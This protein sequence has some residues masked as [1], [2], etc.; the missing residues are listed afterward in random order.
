MVF[1]K[2]AKAAIM[3][4]ILSEVL[5]LEDDSAVHK[6]FARE[7]ITGPHDILDLQDVAT[8]KE[9]YYML[10]VEQDDGTVVKEREH[11]ARGHIGKI[12]M[13][14]KFIKYK[15]ATVGPVDDDEWVNISPDKYNEY[16]MLTPLTPPTVLPTSTTTAVFSRNDAL[17]DFKRGVKRDMSQFETLKDDGA[18]DAWNRST[19]AQA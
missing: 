4:H 11:L 18:W 2:N 6:V 15:S 16:R 14:I 1:T 12:D 5:G 8:I 10:E 19:I 17:R 13:F 9:L 7:Q 3:K